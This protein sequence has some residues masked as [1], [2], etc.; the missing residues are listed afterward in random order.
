VVA[1][2]AADAAS[3]PK[4]DRVYKEAELPDPVRRSLPKLAFGGSSW[5][6]AAS[7]RMVIWNGRVFHEGDTIAPG[8]V[9]RRIDR[10]S[11]LL[12][13]KGYRVEVPF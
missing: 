2:A 12:A 9:L 8:V 4:D 13:A 1:A 10:K 6:S 5:S 3:E 11:A 7:S